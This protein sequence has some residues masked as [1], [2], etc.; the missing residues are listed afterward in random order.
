MCL[1]KA[2][3]HQL[4]LNDER[5]HLFLSLTAT[6]HPLLSLSSF[7]QQLQAHYY[8]PTMLLIF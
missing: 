5:F 8:S 1:V 6:L 3:N 4:L 2:I 7:K